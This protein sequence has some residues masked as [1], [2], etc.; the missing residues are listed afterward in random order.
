MLYETVR[1]TPDPGPPAEEFPSVTFKERAEKLFPPS[2]LIPPVDVSPAMTID[3]VK[4][5]NSV[6]RWETTK[7]RSAQLVVNR[8]KSN[9]K[10]TTR[11]KK[12][13]KSTKNRMNESQQRRAQSVAHTDPCARPAA[14]GVPWTP[15]FLSWSTW[16]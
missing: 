9:H 16:W 11:S 8:H 14:I 1:P 13:T 3:E 10:T 12:S 6:Q 5:S 15:S 2:A 4:D 7:T